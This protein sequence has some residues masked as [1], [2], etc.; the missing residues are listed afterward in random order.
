[1]TPLRATGS[2]RERYEFAVQSQRLARL[3]PSRPSDEEVNA[4]VDKFIAAHSYRVK[5]KE[6]PIEA[7]CRQAQAGR[8]DDG[9]PFDRHMQ[10]LAELLAKATPKKRR[11]TDGHLK[12]IISASID[13]AVAERQDDGPDAG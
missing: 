7:L 9:S 6:N 10:R 1:M 12:E 4:I 11:I 2:D 13:C 8:N 5:R 3:A